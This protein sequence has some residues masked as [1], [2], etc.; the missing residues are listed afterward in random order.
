MGDNPLDYFHAAGSLQQCNDE[1]EAE[2]IILSLLDAFKVQYTNRGAV[3][4]NIGE[5]KIDSNDDWSRDALACST[6]FTRWY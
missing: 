1:D 5:D 4:N 6:C 3:A 2:A